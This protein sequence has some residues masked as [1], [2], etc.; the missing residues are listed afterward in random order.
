MAR[1]PAP[2]KPAASAPVP[3]ARPAARPRTPAAGAPVRRASTAASA[4]AASAPAEREGRTE[5][6]GGRVVHAADRFRALLRPRPW[7]RHRRRIIAWGAGTVLLLVA[8]LIT[9]VSLPQLQVQRVDVVGTTYVSADEVREAAAGETGS[10]VLLLP[11]GRIA[12]EVEGVPGVASAEV[13]RQWPDGARIAVTERTPLAQLTDASGAVSIL[14]A[15]GT[16]LPSSAT[17]APDGSPRHL[18][19]LTIA[20]GAADP[21]A[22]TSSMLE[23]LAALPEDFRSSVGQIAA[24][25]RTDVTL[26]VQTDQGTRTVVWG[27]ASDSELKANVAR[28]LLGQPGTTIDVTS[29]IAPVTR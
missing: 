19:A 11:A 25:S 7:R 4:R 15:T 21:A 5:E 10:S 27:D 2:P 14:D 8:L 22:A 1:R 12:R 23:V 9:A 3:P 18:T 6:E 24:S 17:Q 26:T 13:T 16:V 20:D 29:P 28:A